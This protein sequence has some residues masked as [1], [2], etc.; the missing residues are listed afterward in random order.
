MACGLCLCLTLHSQLHTFSQVRLKIGTPMTQHEQANPVS[1][2]CNCHTIALRQETTAPFLTVHTDDVC[3]RGR[4]GESG[5]NPPVSTVF[6]APA[7][8]RRCPAAMQHLWDRSDPAAAITHYSWFAHWSREDCSTCGWMQPWLPLLAV[9][10]DRTLLRS[11]G[12]LTCT[13][14]LGWYSDSPAGTRLLGVTGPEPVIQ[15]SSK[16]P[17][18]APGR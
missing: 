13:R 9:G 2:A 6:P 17:G 12:C 11:E 5:T 10:R 1:K 3:T 15:E 16:G 8:Q 4:A 7:V 18:A 14:L